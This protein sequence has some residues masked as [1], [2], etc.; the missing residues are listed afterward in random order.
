MLRSPPANAG[1]ASS[2]PELGRSPGEGNGH[3]SSI[4]AWRIPW[5]EETDALQPMG[6]QRVEHALVTKLSKKSDMTERLSRTHARTHSLTHPPTR[7][8]SLFLY[9]LVLSW[10]SATTADVFVCRMGRKGGLICMVTVPLL[11]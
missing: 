4:L 10:G 8:S 7:G 9:I 2:I 11:M 3:H 1:D 6:S 5:I